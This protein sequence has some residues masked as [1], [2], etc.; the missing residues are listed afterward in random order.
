MAQCHH[1]FI[2]GLCPGGAMRKD[3]DRITRDSMGGDVSAAQEMLRQAQRRGDIDGQ[4]DAAFAILIDDD[5]NLETQKSMVE[6]LT[7]LENW[8]VV[9]AWL[10]DQVDALEEKSRCPECKGRETTGGCSECDGDHGWIQLDEAQG[11]GNHIVAFSKLYRARTDVLLLFLRCLRTWYPWGWRGM[12]EDKLYSV[13]RDLQNCDFYPLLMRWYNT[14]AEN[15]WDDCPNLFEIPTCVCI[16]KGK[17]QRCVGWC[18]NCGHGPC[19]FTEEDGLFSRSFTH[20]ARVNK[21]CEA[22]IATYPRRYEGGCDICGDSGN[23]QR[24]NTPRQ[25]RY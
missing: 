7:R 8:D 6:I 18:Q 20:M 4:V 22:T 11:I 9:L 2:D 12:L 3:L 21:K 15:K 5:S 1:C 23:C 25:W 13:W 10:L 14:N 16:V 17:C 19:E 24:C